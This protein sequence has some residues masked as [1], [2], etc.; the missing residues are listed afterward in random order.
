ML[1]NRREGIHPILW[2]GKGHSLKLAQ[3][4]YGNGS[5]P[6]FRNALFGTRYMDEQQWRKNTYSLLA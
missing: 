4:S 1:S 2:Y 6:T 3:A 5:K